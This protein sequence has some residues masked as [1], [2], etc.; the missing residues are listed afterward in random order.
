MK[1]I[2]FFLLA[3]NPLFFF[4]QDQIADKLYDQGVAAFNLGDYKSADS[5]FS[6]SAEMQPNMDVYYNLAIVKNRLGDQCESC[7]YMDLAGA[8]GD[9]NARKKYNKNCL[10]KDSVVYS[11]TKFYCLTEQKFCDEK[12]SFRFYKKAASGSD[13]AVLLVKDSLLSNEIL[14][15]TSF[16]IEKFVDTI[17]LNYEE[18]PGYP[19]GEYALM[20]FLRNNIKYPQAARENGIQGTVFLIFVVEPD[21]KLSNISVLRGIGGGCD[22]EAIRVI[23][24][25]PAWKPGKQFGKPVRV[26]FNLPLRF[27]LQG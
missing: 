11:N 1:S 25:M 16:E 26:Q 2:L 15:S 23:S 14:L 8:N 5:L 7:K 24:I 20:D 10:K 22:E 12:I 9:T 18:Q 3:I 21:G 4:A 6:L 17:V 13:S 19:G 27:I